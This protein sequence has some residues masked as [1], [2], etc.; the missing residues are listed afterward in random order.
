MKSRKHVALCGIMAVFIMI[1][2]CVNDHM[3]KEAEQTGAHNS[4]GI[5]MNEVCS[6][7]FPTSFAETQ[8]ASDWIELYNYSN[9]SKNLSE[10][11]LSDDKDDLHKYKLPEVEL[12]P[13]DYYVIHCEYEEMTEE[14]K[15]LNFRI[16]AQGETIY[17]SVEG[18]VIDAV[19]VP[20]LEIN[21]SWS[22]LTDAGHEWGIRN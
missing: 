19:S 8:P 4:Y 5:C 20:A 2:V 21:T 3:N 13:G 12:L 7:Y 15:C 10:Y 14:E 22:R 16:K 18:G 9:T 1:A 17:L 11:Y 6:A